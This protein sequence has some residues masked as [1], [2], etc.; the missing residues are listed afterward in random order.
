M[1]SVVF[2]EEQPRVGHDRIGVHAAWVGQKQ[3]QVFIELGIDDAASPLV[4]VGLMKAPSLFS[5]KAIRNPARF[6]APDS[7]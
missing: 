7:T 1:V 5:S 6:A 3:S 2:V 4:P